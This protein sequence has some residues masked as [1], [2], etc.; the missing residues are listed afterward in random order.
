MCEVKLDVAKA[1][2]HRR[3][4]CGALPRS[5][6][7]KR[8]P[9]TRKLRPVVS[10]D[11]LPSKPVPHKG[12]LSRSDAE[13][14]VPVPA[15][16]RLRKRNPHRRTIRNGP[17]S[18]NVSATHAPTKGFSRAPDKNNTDLHTIL[19]TQNPSLRTHPQNTREVPEI[20]LRY[21]PPRKRTCPCSKRS[22][23]TW[24]GYIPDDPRR[25]SRNSANM[26]SGV[27]KR[28]FGNRRK[29]NQPATPL[30]SNSDRSKGLSKFFKGDGKNNQDDLN[31]RPEAT[32]RKSRFEA[33]GKKMLTRVKSMF[34]PPSSGNRA[35]SNPEPLPGLPYTEF[36]AHGPEYPL[37]NVIPRP[38]AGGSNRA[39]RK[40]KSLYG[41]ALIQRKPAPIDT[42]TYNAIMNK[43]RAKEHEAKDHKSKEPEPN[44]DK[45]LGQEQQKTN[46]HNEEQ[47]GQFNTPLF[48]GPPPDNV[49]DYDPLDLQRN[50]AA[51]Q[52]ETEKYGGWGH[53]YGRAAGE[54]AE[55][56]VAASSDRSG[57]GV[58]IEGNGQQMD[59]VASESLEPPV[60]EE[61]EERLERFSPVRPQERFPPYSTIRSGLEQHP[62]VME[63]VDPPPGVS[64][65]PLGFEESSSS[66]ESE[67]K[68]EVESETEHGHGN[69]SE[70]DRDDGPEGEHGGEHEGE[71]GDEHRGDGGYGYDGYRDNAPHNGHGDRH[72]YGT[73]GTGYNAHNGS[74]NEPGYEAEDESEHEAEQKTVRFPFDIYVPGPG[75]TEN[76]SRSPSPDSIEEEEATIHVARAMPIHRF[77]SEDVVFRYLK[78]KKQA[79]EA[80]AANPNGDTVA[81]FDDG[82]LSQPVTMVHPRERHQS[83][84]AEVEWAEDL[85]IEESAENKQAIL[86][87]TAE[88][89]KARVNRSLPTLLISSEDDSEH[90]QY[91]IPMRKS[92]TFVPKP[93]SKPPHPFDKFAHRTAG[94]EDPFLADVPKLQSAPILPQPEIEE[95]LI[96][97]YHMGR[98]RRSGWVVPPNF[99][100]QEYNKWDSSEQ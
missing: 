96:S 90:E 61:T 57:E 72:Q 68:T 29:P 66:S 51:F 86:E 5:N 73:S 83:F 41:D 52:A 12:D 84:S 50:V 20:Q 87:A 81:D 21:I 3:M 100:Y 54:S 42:H 40:V 58:V 27:D 36:K 91:R 48:G 65:V 94:L 55:G 67:D 75:T 89:S 56:S 69:E 92:T 97:P 31:D 30:T 10:A 8:T 74:E 23:G 88:S 35:A 24:V 17:S 26:E 95:P 79:K 13:R 77:S 6:E 11:Y 45:S 14:S 1:Y 28:G 9:D 7:K 43:Q 25:A 19:H 22:S 46:E 78:R 49:S 37:P 16:A 39:C 76:A 71:R 44:G 82:D 70:H 93:V 4:S 85:D 80:A 38:A 62:F 15:R 2:R 63:F 18:T 53:I 32:N 99:N 98:S 60:S 33:G 34:F 47:M 59:L 64:L